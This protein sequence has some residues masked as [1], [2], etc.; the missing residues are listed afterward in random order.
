MKCAGIHT[1]PSTLLD[2]I[3]VLSTKLSI[4]LI[5]TDG[6]QLPLVQKFYP[7]F[8]PLYKDFSELTLEYLATHC[9]ALLCSRTW[10]T[11][12]APLFELF[13]QKKMRFIC[14]PH[15]NSDKTR[16]LSCHLQ[17]DI[18]LMYGEQM[19]DLSK[20][21]AKKGAATASLPLFTGNY[22]Y[23]YFC[24]HRQFYDTLVQDEILS[25]FKKGKKILLYAPTWQDGEN[26][27]SFFSSCAELIETIPTAYNLIIKLHPFLE[28][29][30]P[31][32]ILHFL[33]QYEE[34]PQVL[35]LRE[36]P[37]IYPLLAHVD[38]YVGDFSSI[39]YDFLIFDKPLY[40]LNPGKG[41]LLRLCGLPI[42]GEGI[43]S[44]IEKTLEYNQEHFAES[45]KRIYSY[46][47]GAEKDPLI[48]KG[49][50]FDA[51]SKAGS[52]KT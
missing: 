4:P 36:F 28:E 48:L 18:T 22:R 39:G 30:H 52:T 5:V 19:L 6:A 23:A 9:D 3:G 31:A 16:P 45:R 11:E 14:Y 42:Q 2:H 33:G 34:H 24:E 37:P 1:G 17:Q 12:L 15:G 38:L 43:F 35:F 20:R 13:F 7:D 26:G 51:L 29:R 8:N 49:E 41:Q 50:I 21:Y 27:S 44:F 40:F 10:A 32:R 46:A 47:F 25:R